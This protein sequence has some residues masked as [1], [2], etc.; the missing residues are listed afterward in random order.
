MGLVL[1][2]LLI[3][4]WGKGVPFK[5]KIWGDLMSSLTLSPS[6]RPFPGKDSIYENQETDRK[7]NKINFV[8]LSISIGRRRYLGDV[9]LA[10][11][12]FFTIYGLEV[13]FRIYKSN[14][15]KTGYDYGSGEHVTFRYTSS[16]NLYFH[17][18][19]IFNFEIS[20]R[21]SLYPD[22]IFLNCSIGMQIINY[23]QEILF[24][25]YVRPHK[26]LIDHGMPAFPW[27]GGLELHFV[28]LDLP[29]FLNFEV[30]HTPWIAGIVDLLDGP[31]RKVEHTLAFSLGL[32]YQFRR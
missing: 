21:F 27:G 19:H 18:E 31:A 6:Q 13:T 17:T 22:L 5:P 25:N 7:S 2:I 15:L 30:K 20:R 26:M 16:G 29:L 8:A 24:D 4:E 12:D 32:G 11:E 9:I 23:S 1:V 28:K 10:P 3:G 14:Y